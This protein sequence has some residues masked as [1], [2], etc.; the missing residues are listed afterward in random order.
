MPRRPTS[1]VTS[2]L[3]RLQEAGL[4]LRGLAR[5]AKRKESLIIKIARGER[6]MSRE[7]ADQ[8]AAA[9]DRLAAHCAEA[10]ETIRAAGRQHG[11]EDD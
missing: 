8:L 6:S 3:R 9:L 4:S 10:A 2:T 1:S 5:L 7:V 11:R